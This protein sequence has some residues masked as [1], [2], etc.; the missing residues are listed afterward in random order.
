VTLA[1]LAARPTSSNSLTS[2][3]FGNS[4]EPDSHVTP[5]ELCFVS[6]L[7]YLIFNGVFDRRIRTQ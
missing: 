2:W 5:V 1:D 6:R 7:V 4:D 3:A